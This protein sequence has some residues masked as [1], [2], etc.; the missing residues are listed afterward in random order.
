MS[1]E[2]LIE[3]FDTP[4]TDETIR[5]IEAGVY[6]L[7]DEGVEGWWSSLKKTFKKV[8]K[9]LTNSLKPVADLARVATN[10][11]VLSNFIPGKGVIKMGLG[12]FDDIQKIEKHSGKK[13]RFTP[14][15][16]KNLSSAMYLKGYKDGRSDEAK[17]Q[18]ARNASATKPKFSRNKSSRS[19]SSRSRFSRR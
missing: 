12:M 2:I 15:A 16:T 7:S 1:N 14:K 17:E 6:D 9:P 13:I 3:G 19:S 18:I 8:V 4:E 10:V 11:P 5:L